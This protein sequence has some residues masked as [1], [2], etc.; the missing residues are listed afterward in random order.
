MKTLL[1]F[2]CFCLYPICLIA[3]TE[4]IVNYNFGF[5]KRT[6]SGKLPDD[7]IKWGMAD[8]TLTIDTICKFSGLQSLRIEPLTNKTQNSFGCCSYAIPASLEGKE[9]QRIGIIPDLTIRPSINGL[10]EG[11]DELLEKAIEIIQKEA[12]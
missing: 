3:Q 4:P 2:Y 1:L 6:N 9:T 12:F 10:K 7:W 8:Y 5:E 11:R